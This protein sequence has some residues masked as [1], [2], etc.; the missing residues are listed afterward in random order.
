MFKELLKANFKVNCK[1]VTSHAEPL[2]QS[3]LDCV[4]GSAALR[5][6]TRQL[7]QMYL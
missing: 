4:R 1:A 6:H 7:C 3:R 5:E 2:N